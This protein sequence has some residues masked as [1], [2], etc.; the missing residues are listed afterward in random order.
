MIVSFSFKDSQL[1]RK[2]TR[3]KL[4]NIHDED[5]SYDLERTPSLEA[6]RY[7]LERSSELFVHSSTASSNDNACAYRENSGELH[8]PYGAMVYT[9]FM[10]YMARDNILNNSH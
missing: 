9:L 1:K 3:D 2:C 6:S 4:L 10:I 5:T 7:D 8:S